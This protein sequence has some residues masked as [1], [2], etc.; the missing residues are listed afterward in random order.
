[1]AALL[2]ARLDE[3]M[4]LRAQR[5]SEETPE[6]QK[7]RDRYTFLNERLDREIAFQENLKGILSQEQFDAWKSHKEARNANRK[8]HARQ[9]EMRNHGR[10][11]G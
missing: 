5:K 10:R 11:R 6:L 8:Q 9:G 3:G 7:D 4:A 2:K 1:M